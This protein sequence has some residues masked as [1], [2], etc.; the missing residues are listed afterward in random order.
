VLLQ[1]AQEGSLGALRRR[2]HAADHVLPVR[3]LHD[4]ALPPAALSRLPPL[5]PHWLHSLFHAIP[6]YFLEA[7]VVR[8][9]PAAS[10][11]RRRLHWR[12]GRPPRRRSVDLAEGT[13]AGGW[14]AG[15]GREGR[16]PAGRGEL[17]VA[18]GRLV[19]V[20]EGAVLGKRAVRNTAHCELL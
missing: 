14:V 16:G 15:V 2:L 6:L 17:A 19:V 13:V 8:L 20:L 3:D 7:E 18:T 12:D 4:R 5:P 10:Q 9:L 1:L 11:L